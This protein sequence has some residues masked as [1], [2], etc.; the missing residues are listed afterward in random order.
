MGQVGKQTVQSVFHVA[1]M[2]DHVDGA[3]LKQELAALK[4]LRQFLP[5]GLLDNPRTGETDQGTGLGHIDIAKHSQ[6]CGPPTVNR[7]S[8]HRNKRQAGITHTL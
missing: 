8:E 1:A 6:R 5:H 2:D 3:M 4:T 7:I